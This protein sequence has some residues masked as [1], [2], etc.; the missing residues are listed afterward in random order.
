MRMS[1]GDYLNL[2]DRNSDKKRQEL[3]E[4]G[5]ILDLPILSH[6]EINSL[7]LVVSGMM[8]WNKSGT[9]YIVSVGKW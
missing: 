5:D 1:Y 9:G 6:H 8:N 2:S 4:K 3:I 7:T